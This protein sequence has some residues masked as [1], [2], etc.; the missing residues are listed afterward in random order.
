[1][2]PIAWTRTYPGAD[3]QVGRV[4]TSTIGAATDFQSEGLRRL[5]VNASYWCL[6][7]EASIPARANVQTV[8]PYKPTPFGFGTYRRKVKPADH[9]GEEWPRTKHR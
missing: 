3:G 4:F 9:A 6:G 5:L 8:G 2:M 7:M 1:M